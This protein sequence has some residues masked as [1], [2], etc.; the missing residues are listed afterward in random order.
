M[1]EGL[2]IVETVESYLKAN[3]ILHVLSLSLIFLFC[4]GLVVVWWGGGP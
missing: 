2:C 1:Y 3:H 4:E